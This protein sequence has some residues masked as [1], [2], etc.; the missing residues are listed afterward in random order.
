MGNAMESR[1]LALTQTDHVIRALPGT[2]PPAVTDKVSFA[3][4]GLKI[5]CCLLSL[6]AQIFKNLN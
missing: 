6:D 5:F 2:S 3:A 1:Q 4:M